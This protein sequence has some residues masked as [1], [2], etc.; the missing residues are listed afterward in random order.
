[1]NR[2]LLRGACLLAVATAGAGTWLVGQPRL[3]VAPTSAAAQRAPGR[4][5]LYY[6][7]PS[8]ASEFSPTPKKNAQGRDYLPVYEEGEQ[9]PPAAAPAAA[10][11]P[12]PARQPL[13]YQEPSGKPEYS[14]VPR[15]TADGRDFTA[16]YEDVGA[17]SGPV[18]ETAPA[19]PGGRGRVV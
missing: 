1:M 8:N 15:K 2:H 3:T 17:P 9:A 7:D 4:Q 13:Y 18:A 16:V 6:R 19:S 10:P 14:A 5:P 11:A 12:E